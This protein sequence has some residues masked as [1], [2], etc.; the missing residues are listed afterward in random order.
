[1]TTYRRYFPLIFIMGATATLLAVGLSLVTAGTF[2]SSHRL[3]VV[4]RG[5]GL[6]YMAAGCGIWITACRECAG[7]PGLNPLLDLSLLIGSALLLGNL[8]TFRS[9]LAHTLTLTGLLLNGGALIVGL[10]AMLI[11]PAYPCPLA[12]SWPEGGDCRDP[13]VPATELRHPQGHAVLPE[14]LTLIKGIG[15]RIQ[16]ILNEAGIVTYLDVADHTPQHLKDILE[17]YQFK[18]PYDTRSWPEQAQTIAVDDWQTAEGK[19]ETRHRTVF[20]PN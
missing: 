19:G 20:S 8:F 14:D 4:L 7:K 11:A 10:L 6:G 13:H 16:E 9:N 3:L 5:F 2:F 1:M 17:E 18:A 12:M 15:P